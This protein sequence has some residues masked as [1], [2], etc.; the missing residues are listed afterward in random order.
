LSSPV[1]PST[2][3]IGRRHRRGHPDPSRQAGSD[4]TSMSPSHPIAAPP[5]HHQYPRPPNQIESR[6]PM[7]SIPAAGH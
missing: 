6:L 2:Q 4:H 1:A 7:A 5:I 3:P